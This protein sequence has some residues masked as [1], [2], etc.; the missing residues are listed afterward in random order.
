[1]RSDRCGDR[2][3]SPA[4]A[5]HLLADGDVRFVGDPVHP[6]LGSNLSM[7]DVGGGFGQKV[8]LGRE[9]IAVMVC[10]RRLDRP[11]SWIEGRSENLTSSNHA[12]RDRA[13]V[14]L[15]A[16]ADG[17]FVAATMDHLEDNG[18]YSSGGNPG[19]GTMACIHFP[20]PYR[21]GSVGWRT[22]TVYTNT[23]GRGAYRGPW[24]M[25]SVARELIVDMLAR[26][27]GID[28][29]ELRR[30][31]FLRAEDLPH[32]TATGITYDR[33]SPAECLDQ[34]AEMIDYDGFRA[35][36]REVRAAATE[37]VRG[38]G[39]SPGMGTLPGIGLAVYVEP[40]AIGRGALATEG[41]TVR[42]EPDGSVSVYAG[43]GSHGQSLETTMA[44]I[45]ADALGVHPGDVRFHQGHGHPTDS[46]LVA[47]VRRSSPGA[48][49]G[50]PRRECAPSCCASPPSCWR[51][52]RTTW[53]RPAAPFPFAARPPGG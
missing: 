35:T 6:E 13:D 18:A 42:I 21:L 9:E 33:I 39:G 24:Q 16:S 43:T 8:F 5:D 28:P 15:G 4:R 22:A 37:S 34:V 50:Q 2:S 31:K 19:N 52:H 23:C 47:A 32:T 41:S 49:R 25:E 7:G 27:L 29:L 26:Q 30:R 14:R 46:A 36:H 20:G 10:S 45:V 40:S 48:R 11:V 38:N 3:C 44:Q 53:S 1:M 12:R 17:R 51:P